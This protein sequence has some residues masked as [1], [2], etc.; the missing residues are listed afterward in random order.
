MTEITITIPEDKLRE[1]IAKSIESVLKSEYSNPFADLVKKALSDQS[2]P[3]KTFIDEIIANALTQP[4]FKEKV[5]QVVITKLVES[6]L[7]R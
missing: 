4:E 1:G 6:A 5:S 7:K 3:L 2:G